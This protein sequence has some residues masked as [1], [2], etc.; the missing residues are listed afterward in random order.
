MQGP[1]DVLRGIVGERFVGRGPCRMRWRVRGCSSVIFVERG[2]LG[3]G[4][5]LREIVE[6][7]H[8]N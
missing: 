6:A 1:F 2:R 4:G 8:E 3:G 7:H 5:L